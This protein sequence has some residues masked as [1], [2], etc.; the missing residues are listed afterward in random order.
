MAKRATVK[1]PETPEVRDVAPV[2][3]PSGAQEMLQLVT[4]T[5]GDEEYGMPIMGVQEILRT[6][7]VKVTQIP[8][9]PEF[10]DGV[11]NLRGR[12]IPVVDLRT[13]F[14]MPKSE[15]ERSSRIVVA[16]VDGRTV[17]LVVDAVIEV[18]RVSAAEIEPLPEVVASLESRF[19]RGVVRTADRLVIVLDLT[20]LFSGEEQESLAAVVQETGEGS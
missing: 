11:M 2:Q 18:A 4:L 17:G 14:H 16:D 7:N 3:V 13:R 5:L 1:A 20:G 8:S 6:R 9:T 10:V 19:V 15:R 12:V